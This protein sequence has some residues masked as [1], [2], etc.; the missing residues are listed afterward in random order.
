LAANGMD[1]KGRAALVTGGT[2]GIGLATATSLARQGANLV[3]GARSENPAVL[4]ELAAIAGQHGARCVFVAGDVRDP[5]TSARLVAAAQN[6]FGGVDAVVHAAGGPAPGTALNQSYASWLD[7]FDVHVNSAF[8]LFRAAHAGLAASK[9]AVV[10]L[11]SAAA[12]RGCPG[13]I[14]YQTV[15]AALIQMARALARDHA[16]E[17]IRVNCVAPGIIRTPFQA[18]MTEEARLNNLKNRIPLGREGTPEQVASMIL[19]LIGNE[20]I[21]GETVVLDGGMSMRMV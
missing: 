18:G 1:L 20:F 12:L 17:G 21:T 16:A 14:A 5:D 13:T 19:Q 7:A 4:S 9:G 8:H 10:L 11:S 2:S 3:L 6:E 15:K